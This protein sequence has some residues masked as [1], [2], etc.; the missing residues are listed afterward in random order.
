MNQD[1]NSKNIKEFMKKNT[2]QDLDTMIIMA[3]QICP[4]CRLRSMF[5][6]GIK[7]EVCRLCGFEREI[8]WIGF[9]EDVKNK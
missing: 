5:F 8:F 9:K 3:P 1:E 2:P 4:I 6:I 7:K